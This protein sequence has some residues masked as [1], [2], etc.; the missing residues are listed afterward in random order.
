MKHDEAWRTPRFW[1]ISLVAFAACLVTLSLG[2]WQ[3]SRAAE[4]QA[5]HDAMLSQRAL[6][7]LTQAQ[8]LQGGAAEA[9]NLHRTVVLRGS[10]RP[11]FTVF[12]DNRQMNGRQGFFVLT[13]LQLSASNQ[14]IMVQRGWIQRDFTDRSRLPEL[15]TPS[16]E[17]VVTGR[18]A[19][20]PAR[21]LELGT[22]SVGE[23]SS[24]IRQNLDLNTYGSEIHL[25]LLPAT[26]VQTDP[27]SDGL[28][29]DWFEPGAG[30]EKHYGYAFQWFGLSGL[31]AFLYVWFQ[32][33]RRIPRS[34]SRSS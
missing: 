26:V 2:R 17:V 1:L 25:P 7:P 31:I 32:I 11:E 13:P 28:S 4:K 21:L 15:R 34:K 12:L 10:W 30:T 6:P 19:G 29:R 24:R 14:S 16:G 23:G 5:L 27:A 8:W 9:G 3:L 22:A 18:V 20:P 33:V